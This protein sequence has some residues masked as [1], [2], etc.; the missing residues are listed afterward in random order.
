VNPR[1]ELVKAP[2]FPSLALLSWFEKEARA[3]PWREH[4]DP[5]Q[6][7]LSEMMC[8]QTQIATAL[9]YFHRWIAR[10]PNWSSLALAKES[11]VLS[12]WEGLGYYQRARRLLA[13][14]KRLHLDHGGLLPKEREA[15]FELPGLGPYTVAAIRTIAFNLVDFPIDGN[16][17]RV[18]SRFY[19]DGS[20]SPS[21]Q[22][23]EAFSEKML[24]QFRRVRRRRELAQALMELGA[25][26]CRPKKALCQSCPIQADCCSAT[27]SRAQAFPVKK[28][29]AKAKVLHLSFVWIPESGGLWLRQRS[30]K[31]RFPSQYEAPNVEAP[32]EAESKG[33][34]CDGL[35]VPVAEVQWSGP[36][37]RDFT[38]YQVTWHE[39]VLLN[40]MGFEA[41]ARLREQGFENH[42]FDHVAGLNLIPLLAKRLRLQN[43]KNPT[44]LLPS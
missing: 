42:P 22:Q 41:E 4:Y 29:K 30:P 32:T 34:L 15:L 2:S 3:L 36:I 1:G 23:D 9:P 7:A 27:P 35:C 38:T 6:I 19:G 10:W 24:P 33:R 11:E 28:P 31:G 20:F 12:A 14:A 16:V 21:K 39:G 40:S 18:L 25:M 13:L 17:R 26:V 37:R 43:F 8:Q 44:S 5:Y